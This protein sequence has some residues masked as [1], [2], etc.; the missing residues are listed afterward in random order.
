MQL[1]RSAE[2]CLNTWRERTV[3]V[4][5]WRASPFLRNHI[6]SSSLARQSADFSIEAVYVALQFNWCTGDQGGRGIKT[7]TVHYSSSSF[8]NKPSCLCLLRSDAGSNFT[9]LWLA[10]LRS[11]TLW[12]LGLLSDLLSVACEIC[13]FFALRHYSCHCAAPL[14][15]ASRFNVSRHRDVVSPSSYVVFNEQNSL[16]SF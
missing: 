13:A 15:P 9:A 10:S 11:T 14:V 6:R 16:H 8:D 7:A 5:G 2:S 4:E 12:V 3:R 1:T